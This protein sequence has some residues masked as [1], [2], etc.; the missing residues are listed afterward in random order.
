M[1]LSSI[2]VRPPRPKSGWIEGARRLHLVG[3]NGAFAGKP[4]NDGAVR[5]ILEVV[6]GQIPVQLGGGIRDLDTIERYLDLGIS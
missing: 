5:S 1:R 6:D 4:V 2:T 3:L